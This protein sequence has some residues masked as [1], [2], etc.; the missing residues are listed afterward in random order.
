M[1]RVEAVDAALETA[2]GGHTAF[3]CYDSKLYVDEK[4]SGR[5][6]LVVSPERPR[7][8]ATLVALLTHRI[9]MIGVGS[10]A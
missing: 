2:A 8:R 5:I 6:I 4:P 3:I 9:R 7:T 10:A 1:R